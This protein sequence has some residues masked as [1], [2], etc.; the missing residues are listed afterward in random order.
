MLLAGAGFKPVCV[1]FHNSGSRRLCGCFPERHRESRPTA[2]VPTPY[3]EHLNRT[4]C[5]GADEITAVRVQRAICLPGNT[6]LATLVIAAIIGVAL[7][8]QGKLLNS[9]E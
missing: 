8:I 2:I 9:E 7:F 6:W 4:A 5:E 1:R 3:H